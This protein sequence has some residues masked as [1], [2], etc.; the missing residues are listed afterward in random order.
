MARSPEPAPLRQI[1]PT[2]VEFQDRRLCYF[3]G[4]DY[5]RLSWDA[6][7]RAAVAKA[8]AEEGH[9]VAAS[10]MTTGNHPLY[11]ELERSLARFFGFPA[12]LITASG[13]SAPLTAAQALS[14]LVTHVLIDGRAHSCLKDAAR[15]LGVEAG[16]FAHHDPA[17]LKR[18]LRGCGK[19]A[20][21]LVL[22][23]GL[24]PLEGTV[25]ALAE[26]LDALPAHGLL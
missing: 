12:A 5:F 6:G 1:S 14:G 3:G 10:R 9:N 2:E 11:A 15:M 22:T 25:P 19:K 17:G 18:S 7:L 8:V 23:D 4:S 16:F 21:P 26:Y 13:Y 20:K 24:S